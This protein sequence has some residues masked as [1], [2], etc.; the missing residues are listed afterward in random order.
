MSVLPIVYTPM[1]VE[2]LALGRVPGATVMRSGMGPRP[3]P[4]TGPA[5]VAG[6]A[7]SLSLDVRPGDVV[8][9]S[10]VRGSGLPVTIP[11]AP[12]LAAALRRLGLRVHVG[13]IVSVSRPV[14]GAGRQYL[15]GTGALAV[16]M[17]S[18]FLAP[19]AGP[20][21]V[22]RTIVDTPDYPLWRLGTVRRGVTALRALRRV[23]PAIAQWA[24]EV[25]REGVEV[26][27]ES[28][29]RSTVPREVI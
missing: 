8:V 22:V 18:A 20:F 9:A 15:A 23:A 19:A 16:D 11:A 14:D 12:A 13:P 6:V 21:A 17:E 4:S 5:M 28:D 3:A 25:Q 26:P 2:R 1:R 29:I 7:G 27:V 24:E 10:E